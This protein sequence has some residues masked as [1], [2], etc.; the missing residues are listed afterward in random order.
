MA[1]GHK[2]GSL[3]YELYPNLNRAALAAARAEINKALQDQG[4][5]QRKLFSEKLSDFQKTQKIQQQSDKDNAKTLSDQIKGVQY[6]AKLKAKAAADEKKAAD[7]AAKD[8]AKDADAALKAQIREGATR[9][10]QIDATQKAERAAYAENS[11][12]E[13]VK[14]AG[15]A[16]TEA[17]RQ[18]AALKET[19]DAKDTESFL[20]R[21]ATQFR[22][23][24]TLSKGIGFGL[25]TVGSFAVV[26]DAVEGIAAAVPIANAALAATPALLA[27]I[28]TEAILLKADFKGVSQAITDSFKS[29]DAATKRFNNE[30]AQLGPNTRAAVTSIHDQFTKL[31]LPGLQDSFFGDANIKKAIANSGRF[32]KTVYPGIASLNTANASL[33]GKLATNLEGKGNTAAIKDFFKNLSGG[34]SNAT[35]GLVKLETGLTTFIDNVSKKFPNAGKAI[36]DALAKLGDKL[37]KANVDSIFHKAKVALQAFSDIAKPLAGIVD[38]LFKA[39]GD[40]TGLKTLK[41]FGDFLQ[42][43]NTYAKSTQGQQFLHELLGT[44]NALAGFATT[45]VGAALRFLS[46]FLSGLYPDVKPFLDAVGGLASALA[47]LGRPLGKLLGE[48]LGV[49]ATV[50]KDVTPVIKDVVGFLAKHPGV[51][52]GLAIGIGAVY[53]SLVITRGVSAISGAIKGITGALGWFSSPKAAAAVLGMDSVAAAEDGVGASAGAAASGGISSLVKGILGKAG[54]IVAFDMMYTQLNNG[55]GGKLDSL[56]KQIENLFFGDPSK[57]SG[58]T[59][60]NSPLTRGFAKLFHWLNTPINPPKPVV[61][62]L[63][64]TAPGAPGNIKLNPDG[65]IGGGSAG[66][67]GQTPSRGST[68]AGPISFNL[69]STSGMKTATA[70]FNGLAGAVNSTTSAAKAWAG[71]FPAHVQAGVTQ[72]SRQ[73]ST[74]PRTFTTPITDQFN[75]VNRRSISLWG[76]V[77]AQTKSGVTTVGQHTSVLPTVFTKPI[78]EQYSTVSAKTAAMWTHI[79]GSFTAGKAG[80]KTLIASLPSVLTVPAKKTYNSQIKN[81]GSM[82]NSVVKQFAL[83]VKNSGAMTAGLAPA[84]S[85]GISGLVTLFTQNIKKVWDSIA[86]P[87]KLAKLSPVSYKAV[88]VSSPKGPAAPVQAPVFVASGGLIR[89]AGG[90]REDKIP[91]MLSDKEFVVQSRYA[92]QHRSVLEAINNGKFPKGIAKGYASGGSVESVPEVLGWL[93]SIAGRVPYVLGANGPNAFDCSSLVGNVWARLTGH[94][95]NTRYF[96]TGTER[97]WLLSH[98]FSPGAAPGGF[99]VGL[100]SPPEHTVGILGGHRFEAA[101]SGTRMRFD[102]GATNALSMGQQFHMTALGNGAEAITDQ[103]VAAIKKAT[104]RDIPGNSTYAGMLR[105]IPDQQV[106]KLQKVTQAAQKKILES[107]SAFSVNGGDLGSGGNSILGWIQAAQQFDGFPNSWIPGIETIIRRESGGNPNAINRIDANARAGH[108]SQGLMQ[109]IPST[110]NTYVPAALRHLGIL[111]PVANIAAAVR[112]IMSRYKTIFNVQQADPNRAPRGYAAGTPGARPGWAM[113]GERGPEMVNF[114]GGEAVVPNH[115]LGYAK[116]TLPAGL[117]SDVRN[118][119]TNFIKTAAGITSSV[120]VLSNAIKNNA[121]ARSRAGGILD[122]IKKTGSQLEGLAGQL[123]TNNTYLGTLKTA[124]AN[125]KGNVTGTI[126]GFSDLSAIP[127]SAGSGASG[128]FRSGIDAQLGRAQKYAAAIKKVSKLGLSA[129]VIAQL[130]STS[131]GE[132]IIENLALG[133]KADIARINAVTKQIGSL[134]SSEGASISTAVYN[135]SLKAATAESKSLTVQMKRVANALEGKVA[136]RLGIHRKEGGYVPRVPGITGDNVPLLATAG[137]LVLPVGAKIPTT[138]CSCHTTV[139]IDGVELAQKETV[140]QFGKKVIA[141][142]GRR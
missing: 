103:Q 49:L 114:G 74:F 72:V 26:K 112:Y 20:H 35:P 29:G 108:P 59:F 22:T 32:V 77:G 43:I 75:L 34:V 3:Y 87:L 95:K 90:P 28:G 14:R 136:K 63:P 15:E 52:Q 83:G 9:A 97:G 5:A 123:K 57:H 23:I 126:G 69:P 138:G 121:L 115:L 105:A 27:A 91:A 65:S 133:K 132:S 37:G 73:L 70:E 16:K 10:A 119:S 135:D 58:D 84:T 82:W 46:G 102:D 100:T 134:A 61:P 92:Q 18:K 25:K 2:I 6:L 62:S 8:A 76:S 122:T 41:T 111:N 129:G 45:A 1:E 130:T 44:L 39:L 66:P 131:D 50:L 78:E 30:M 118:I 67:G 48:G 99:T 53:T 11:R 117:Q 17:V 31:H 104:L 86:G 142:L 110:F 13:S 125:I 36:G 12:L 42:S 24:G 96:V 127:F 140:T 137:E 7:T 139:M 85:P 124:E 33:F 113:V 106:P 101:H 19:K 116:G 60:E 141:S 56:D 51:L 4:L 64:N 55:L 79:G 38:T 54:L 80:I 128:Q 98:G 107:F 93:K 88:S 109:T 81:T 71:L 89:G 21:L 68:G 47:P 40:P 120:N 94:E